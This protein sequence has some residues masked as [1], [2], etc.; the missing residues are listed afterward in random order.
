MYYREFSSINVELALN[1]HVQYQNS[2]GE[3]FPQIMSRISG[4]ISDPNF[5]NILESRSQLQGGQQLGNF[6]PY[7]LSQVCV[8]FWMD[9]FL[10]NF[11]HVAM[12]MTL[13]ASTKLT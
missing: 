5:A 2:G 6:N 12:H 13:Q 1:K 8:A 11:G 4:L 9:I 10:I 3:G 7:N